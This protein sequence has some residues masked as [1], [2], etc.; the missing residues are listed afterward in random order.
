MIAAEWPGTRNAKI[1]EG[2]ETGSSIV[3]AVYLTCNPKVALSPRT[4]SVHRETLVLTTPVRLLECGARITAKP[5][6]STLTLQPT[7]RLADRVSGLGSSAYF[8][9]A[10]AVD[11]Q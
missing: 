3:I 4:S 2:L 10:A 8:R 7:R 11:H 9:W 5:R 6:P 1:A